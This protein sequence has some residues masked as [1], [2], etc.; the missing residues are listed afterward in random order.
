M[1]KHAVAKGAKI[2][3][4]KFF[5]IYL[6]PLIVVFVLF[7]YKDRT[8]LDNPYPFHAQ[9]SSKGIDFKLG[10][11]EI[12]TTISTYS[13]PPLLSAIGIPSGLFSYQM[14]IYHSSYFVIKS[15]KIPSDTVSLDV[16]VKIDSQ[17]IHL[18]PNSKVCLP[19]ERATPLE[20]Y[21]GDA[22][23]DGNKAAALLKQN[24]NEPIDGQSEVIVRE[25]SVY[26]KIDMFFGI[27]F[28]FYPLY[29]AAIIALCAVHK[30]VFVK[31][32]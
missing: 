21:V 29:W 10:F 14:C 16:R 22:I 15:E 13:K 11:T 30:F 8:F 25:E 18:P 4:I 26:G 6:V 3:D 12:P 9:F 5:L 24:G 23:N 7:P 19:S 17:T 2:S 27:L 31:K 32:K 1:A 28:T 20:I